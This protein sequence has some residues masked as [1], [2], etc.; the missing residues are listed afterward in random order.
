MQALRSLGS[1]LVLVGA[2]SLV[3]RLWFPGY[4]HMLL[5]WVDHWGDPTGWYIRF[6]IIA[7]GGVLMWVG[8]RKPKTPQSPKP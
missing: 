6:G 1:I 8:S 7:L 3:L 4:Y 2:I 5:T